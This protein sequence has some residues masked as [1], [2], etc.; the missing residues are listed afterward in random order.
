MTIVVGYL[1]TKGGRASL[2][3]ACLLARSGREEP[4]AVTTVV[5]QHWSTPSMARVDAE[6]EAW[7]QQQGEAALRTAAGYL[8]DRAPDVPT[9]L[10]RVEGRSVPSALMRA[11]EDLG[12]DLLVLGSSSDGRIG[13][14]VV[15][16][17]AEPL[18]HSSGI[19][20]AIAPRATVPGTPPPSPG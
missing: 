12:G 19:P 16:S 1:P 9:S 6:F 5:P 17:T 13:Q 3:L 14:V 2:E 8:A 7:A 18:L 15:G 11:C 20:V 4:I 10:H